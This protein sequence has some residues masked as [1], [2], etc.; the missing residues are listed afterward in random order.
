MSGAFASR[1]IGTDAAAQRHMLATV[2]YDSVE[3]LVQAAVPASIHVSPR[4]TTDIPP[5]AT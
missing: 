4:E 5:A 1:H 3:A 2:G